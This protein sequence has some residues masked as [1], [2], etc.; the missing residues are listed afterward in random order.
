M[1]FAHRVFVPLLHTLG[2]RL[3]RSLPKKWSWRSV[4]VPIRRYLLGKQMYC[5][6]TNTP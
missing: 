3:I 1:F 6:Y 5:H 2:A 4:P